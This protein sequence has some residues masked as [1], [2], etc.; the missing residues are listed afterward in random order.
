MVGAAK[1]LRGR[2]E[3][4]FLFVGGG[5]QHERLQQLLRKEGL[6]SFIF[7]QHQPR[8]QLSD[9]LG[10]ADVHW[11]SLRPELEGLIVPSKLYG[12]LAAGRPIFAVCDFDGE[13]SRVVRKHGC[14]VV[15]QPGDFLGLAS[16]IEMLAS[17]DKMR[18]EMGQRARSAS[19]QVFSR[20]TSLGLWS[21][22]ISSVARSKN[23]TPAK[24]AQARAINV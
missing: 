17:N 20:Q 15:I 23:H 24:G 1:M 8:D 22:L 2:P 4:K 14:G 6:T 9:T 13:V 16:A 5:R 3:L 18:A 11:L 12:V 10:A 19:E 21:E 7:K